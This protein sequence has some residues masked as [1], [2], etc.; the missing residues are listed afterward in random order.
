[1]FSLGV[2]YKEI[3][4]MTIL[5]LFAGSRSFGVEAEKLGHNVFSVDVFPFENI[6]LVK[7]ILELKRDDIKF[8]PDVIWASPPCTY[9]SVASIGHHWN[10]DDTPKTKE[11]VLGM[12]VLNKT[13]EIISWFPSS[14]FFIEN[15]TGKMR[16]KINGLNRVKITYCSYGDIRMKPTDIWS[17]HIADAFN[18]NGWTP[19]EACFAGNKMCHHEA[20]PRGSKTGTQGITGSYDRSKVPQELCIEILKSL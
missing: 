6:T 17:N 9:F 10:T 12:D 20:A 18:P 15:P 5:E 19:R 4:E 7:D 1:M 3:K 11:A 8:I 14:I 2:F 13:L 16:R